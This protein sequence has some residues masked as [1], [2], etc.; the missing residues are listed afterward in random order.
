MARKTRQQIFD[1]RGRVLL[2]R[3]GIPRGRGALAN[4]AYHFMRT[5]TW[6]VILLLFAA[7]FI[8]TN[9]VFALILWLGHADVANAHGL[10]DYFWFSVQTLAT[11]GY[12]Y[13]APN[14]TL[15]NVIVT[16]ESFFGIALTALVTGV[17]FARFSTTSAR[18]LFSQTAII[19]DYEG[20]R[21]LMFRM[22][23]ERATAIVEAT[24]HVYISRD[25]KTMTG[26]RVRR[27]YDLALRRT[28]SP[29]FFMSWTTYHT[30]DE[31]S[32]LWGKTAADIKA[33]GT[34]IIITFTGID[35]RLASTVHTRY[36]Y[37]EQD[38]RW[39][40]KFADVLK[41]DAETG[42][43]YLDFEPFHDTEAIG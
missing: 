39:D 21:T 42:K 31:T 34:N 27:I 38:L 7:A 8:G 9:V 20:K 17:F 32:P 33:D 43:R 26:E 28:T 11:I 36:A 16:V 40:H 23:N 19:A 2:E 14:D 6:T 30:I 24:V 5:T 35:D 13:L 10:L 4:D 1:A 12:G 18:V 25:E 29:I 22:A 37:N 41:T 15:S 3:R